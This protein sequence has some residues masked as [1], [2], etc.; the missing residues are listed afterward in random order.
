MSKKHDYHVVP[1]SERGGWDVKREHAE[2]ASDHFDK[3][4][5]AMER[6]RELAREHRTEL[7]EHGRDG[8][9]QDSDSYGSDPFPPKDK[10]H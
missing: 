9:I 6:G 2:R 3:K 1:N 5:D 8:R 10:K 4:S 7:V